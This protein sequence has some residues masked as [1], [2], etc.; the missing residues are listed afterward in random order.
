MKADS[1][2]DVSQA[3]LHYSLVRGEAGGLSPLGVEEMA[4]LA[5]TV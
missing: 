5:G 3:V 2:L 4:A 1:R